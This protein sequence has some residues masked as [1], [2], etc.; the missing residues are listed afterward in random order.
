[1]R[2][3]LLHVAGLLLALPAHAQ[4]VA[5]LPDQV[6]NV[7]LSNRDVNHIVCVGGEVEDVKYSADKGS[8]VSVTGSNAWIKF[9]VKE[10]DDGGEVSREFV[11]VPSEYFV[12]CNG[13]VYTL[14]SQ[15]RDIPAQTIK[16]QPGASQQARANEDLLGP[17]V[18]EERAVSV[19]LAVLQDRV[20]ASFSPVATVSGQWIIDTA[21][22]TV[23]SE[24]RR[25]QVDGADLGVSEYMVSASTSVTLDE[26]MF[27]HSSLGS[28]I[29]TVTLDRHSLAAGETARL[30][31][32]RRGGASPAGSARPAPLP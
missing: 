30:V 24:R 25:L 7:Q 17:L 13:A 27:L 20:P 4:M 19:T 2:S 11:S 6:N 15:P 16:L 3:R 5:A 14:L 21:P 12:T 1:M 8:A 18:E 31:V 9:T 32:V 23:V 22:G 28:N 26:R 10:T 29:F